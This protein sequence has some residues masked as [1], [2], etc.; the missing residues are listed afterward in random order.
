MRVYDL[1]AFRIADLASR[2]KFTDTFQHGL[3][4]CCSRAVAADELFSL[5]GVRADDGYVPDVLG[6]R[7]HAVLVLEQHHRFSCGT[8]RKS[9]MLRA[10]YFFEG[11]VAVAPVRVVEEAETELY[12]EYVCD[13]LIESLHADFAVTDSVPERKHEG[14][15]GAESG[16]DVEAGVD[17]L[18]H[19]IF[20]GV[21]DFMLVVEEFHS[22]AV[23]DHIASES[24]LL[25]EQVGEEPAAAAHRDSVVVVVGTHHAE[26]SGFSEGHAER[27][28]VERAHLARSHFRV[29]T[30]LA[31]T[32]SDRD[33]VDGEV[34]RS[35]HDSALLQ[36]EDHPF[37]ELAHEVR[38][39]S[40][41]LHAASPARVLRDVEDR[42][43]NVGV[44][45]QICFP[46]F[47]L[48]DLGNEL[49]VPCGSLPALGREVCGADAAKSPYPLIGEVHGDAEPGL[50]HEPSLDGLERFD[51][52]F[53]VGCIRRRGVLDPVVLLVNVA[54]AVF[55]YLIAPFRGRQVVLEHAACA[56]E[57]HHLA[58][59][60]LKGHL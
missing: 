27:V 32:S 44:A 30:G 38:V 17:A 42:G 23:G 10:V 59:L 31:V 53:E 1:A 28:E 4:R 21:N 55:P 12:P 50:L 19:S 8:Q 20:V 48:A 2:E 15:R 41:G 18:C 49:L 60:L 29:G 9:L 7:E 43:V 58:G 34:L 24:P 46:G 26:S 25:A 51:M 13:P 11:L 37:A 39:F 33:A 14:F 54:H 36:G 40:V 5:V 56:V 35:G 57:G 45:E 47:D 3:Y 6:Q 16:A 22:F 52:L